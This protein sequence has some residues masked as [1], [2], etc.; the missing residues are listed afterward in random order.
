MA[1]GNRQTHLRGEGRGSHPAIL[2]EVAQNI[3]VNMVYHA[4]TLPKPSVPA[5]KRGALM[6]PKFIGFVL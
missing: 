2:F 1:R 4:I 5:R 6:A 3:P